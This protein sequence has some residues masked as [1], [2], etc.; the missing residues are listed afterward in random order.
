M[1][2][3]NGHRLTVTLVVLSLLGLAA[4]NTK[5]QTRGVLHSPLLVERTHETFRVFPYLLRPSATGVTINWF[6]ETP[7]SGTLRVVPAEGLGADTLRFE[8]RPVEPEALGYTTTEA[9]L[10]LPDTFEGGNFKHSIRVEGLAPGRVYRY[11]VEQGGARYEARFQAAPPSGKNVPVQF[12]VFADS[13]TSP[14]GRITRRT[15]VPGTQTPASTGRPDTL[16]RYLLTEAQGFREN[17]RV[18]RRGAPDFLMIAGDIV[19]GGGYQHAWDEFFFHTAGKFGNLLSYVPLLPAIGNWENYGGKAYENGYA[20]RAIAAG[21]AKYASYFDAPPNGTPAH[22]GFY[23]RTD[24]GPVTVLTLDS[25]NGLPDSTDRDTNVHIDASTYPGDD[26]PDFNPGSR[27]WRWAKRELKAAHDAGQVIF[28]QFHHVPYSS[29]V[30]SLPLTAE[31]SSG[32]AGIPMRVYTSL[33]RKYGVAAVF[34]G[35]N[36]SFEHSVVEGIHFYDVGVAGDGFGYALDCEDERFEN[37]H[38][39]WVAHHD[40]PE[41]WDGTQLVSGGKHYGHLRVAVQPRGAG[42]FDVRITPVYVFPVTD[43][44]GTVTGMERRVY[45]DEVTFSYEPDVA[46]SAP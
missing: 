35:H 13:E 2:N 39:V 7:K 9:G 38:R 1:V 22:R 29:G 28:V 11:V 36:E 8:S 43:E 40:A 37:P 33:F 18:L 45:D 6:T 3:E 32:Q 21:R 10:S 25:S 4:P 24:Y 14:A 42:R 26:L 34:S 17:L 30:H 44:S 46:T 27:Q 15:W 41:H 12:A 19:Q 16:E 20:P 23:Y 5:A 31:G